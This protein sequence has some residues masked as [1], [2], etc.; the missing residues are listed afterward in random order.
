MITTLYR[1]PVRSSISVS[2]DGV[3]VVL[4]RPAVTARPSGEPW[5]VR[6]RNRTSVLGSI[7]F[8]VVSNVAASASTVASPFFLVLKRTMTGSAPKRLATM[9]AAPVASLRNTSCSPER[10][11]ETTAVLRTPSAGA[12]AVAERKEGD[13]QRAELL[14]LLFQFH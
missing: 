3:N 14:K 1:T 6:M 13:E 12:A 5:E 7:L 8:P 9:L 2:F 11:K 10:P 4:L